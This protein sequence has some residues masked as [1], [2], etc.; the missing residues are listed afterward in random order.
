MTD[1][2]ATSE[3]LRA[4]EARF[5][6]ETAPVTVGGKTL[7]IV[8]VRDT[9]RLLE[10]QFSRKDPLADFPFWARVWEASII[11][12]HELSRIPPEK[13]KDMLEIGAGLGVA[14]LFAAAFGHKVTI[15]DYEEDALVLAMMSAQLNQLEDIRFQRLDWLSPTLYERYHYIIG[16]E[17]LFNDRFSVPLFELLEKILAPSGVIYIAHDKSRMSPCRFFEL[18]QHHFRIQCQTRTMRAEDEEF[19]IVLH[20]LV[21]K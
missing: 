18:V 15:T 16:S 12:S 5:G 1:L 21:R 10:A 2:A 13:G 19:H 20:R 6:T 3:R 8:Q 17:V 11:L 4:I 7:Q 9:G 14:G